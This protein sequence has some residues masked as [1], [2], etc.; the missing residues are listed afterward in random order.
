M[1]QTS[2]ESTPGGLSSAFPPRRSSLLTHR[3]WNLEPCPLSPGPAH[4]AGAIPESSPSL[5][6]VRQGGYGRC[7]LA[8]DRL[9]HA[10]LLL[11]R[12]PAPLQSSTPESFD[13]IPIE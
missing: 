13:G 6:G 11:T 7:H 9:N 3:P 8:Q 2:V 10:Q 1:T 5:A 12:I 4:T